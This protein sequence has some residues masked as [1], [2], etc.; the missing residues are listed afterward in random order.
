MLENFGDSGTHLIRWTS[1]VIFNFYIFKYF[2]RSECRPICPVFFK[3]SQKI[4]LIPYFPKFHQKMF[5][6][7]LI[8]WA[9]SV[10]IAQA[11]SPNQLILVLKYKLYQ[12][13]LS[14]RSV[15]LRFPELEKTWPFLQWDSK[16]TGN[17][18]RCFIL[19]INSFLIISVKIFV[20]STEQS[21]LKYSIT[22]LVYFSSSKRRIWR[23]L[24]L[25][26]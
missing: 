21:L 24:I 13:G 26:L 10:S 6:K 22:S 25:Y 5:P 19:R 20:S 14:K 2:L 1:N 9:P 8:H 11:I 3:L 4:E 17:S 16:C 23:E 12:P 7:Y 18:F 15:L